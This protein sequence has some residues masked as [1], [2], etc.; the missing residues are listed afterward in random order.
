V[1]KKAT[2]FNLTRERFSLS[3]TASCDVASDGDEDDG[4]A[5]AVAGDGGGGG[6]TTS[7]KRHLGFAVMARVSAAKR[8]GCDNVVRL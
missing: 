6:L 8:R 1:D 5:G 3:S 2:T 4:R 7:E